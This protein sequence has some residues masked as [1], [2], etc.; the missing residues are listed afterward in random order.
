MLPVNENGYPHAI[1]M[2]LIDG[3]NAKLKQQF[4][5]CA[6]LMQQIVVKFPDRGITIVGDRLRVPRQLKPAS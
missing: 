5:V 6:K 3:L 2:E 4:E 1:T